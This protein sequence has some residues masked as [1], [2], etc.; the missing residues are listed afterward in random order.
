M[1]PL[2]ILTA[3]QTEWESQGDQSAL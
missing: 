1:S 3:V 2:V